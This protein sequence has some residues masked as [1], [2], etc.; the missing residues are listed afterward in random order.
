[1]KKLL[2]LLLAALM[3]VTMVACSDKDKKDDKNSDNSKYQ[4]KTIDDNDDVYG[5]DTFYF[6]NVDSETVIITKFT[7]TDDTAHTVTIPAYFEKENKG[8]KKP[9]I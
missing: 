5:A 9:D 3:I 7:T 2:A 8:I 6:E 1:M 4:S